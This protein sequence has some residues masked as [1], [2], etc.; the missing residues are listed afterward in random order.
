MGGHV[1]LELAVLGLLQVSAARCCHTAPGELLHSDSVCRQAAASSR[2]W[3]T[4]PVSRCSLLL[5]AH[6]LVCAAMLPPRVSSALQAGC[7]LWLLAH[8]LG[9]AALH[10]HMHQG[11]IAIPRRILVSRQ[12]LFL[13]YSWG[14]TTNGLLQ[15]KAVLV[16]HLAAHHKAAAERWA[17]LPLLEQ[18]GRERQRILKQLLK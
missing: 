1:G 9:C 15:D 17:Q 5:L 10:M 18:L 4:V 6:V 12:A 16:R 2:V 3:A 11:C 7:S 13:S 8:V 14:R